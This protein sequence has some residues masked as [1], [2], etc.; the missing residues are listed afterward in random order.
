MRG[1]WSFRHLQ[2]CRKGHWLAL[3]CSNATVLA[4]GA[5]EMARAQ[6]AA[7][8]S[9]LISIGDKILEVDGNKI[10]GLS[11]DRVKA[12]LMGAPGST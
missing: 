11:A 7:A 12:Y 4:R 3:L 9:G 8:E 2:Y 5:N 1:V 10:A 6:S